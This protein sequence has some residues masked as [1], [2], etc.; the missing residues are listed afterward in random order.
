VEVH[1]PL[2]LHLRRSTN[3]A[4]KTADASQGFVRTHQ[5]LMKAIRKRDAVAA[6]KELEARWALAEKVL[7]SL[8]TPSAF[9]PPRLPSGSKP[10]AVK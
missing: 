10:R 9:T 5:R 3:L 8:S 4:L 2:W 1:A 6:V 7:A